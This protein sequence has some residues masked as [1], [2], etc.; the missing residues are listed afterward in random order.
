MRSEGYSSTINDYVIVKKEL[1]RM[2]GVPTKGREQ[3]SDGGEFFISLVLSDANQEVGIF[4]SMNYIGLT[5]L[6]RAVLL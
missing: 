1:S 2:P 3:K 5:N 4:K 6:S